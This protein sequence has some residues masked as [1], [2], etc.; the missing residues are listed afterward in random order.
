MMYFDDLEEDFEL[1][2][3]YSVQDLLPVYEEPPSYEARGQYPPA[4]IPALE[5]GMRQMVCPL[6]AFLFVP[7]NL[8][9]QDN[10][11]SFQTGA[12]V[13]VR[14]R[15]AYTRAKEWLGCRFRH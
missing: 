2:P 3:P 14:V 1:A 11:V 9:A 10:V 15:K 12:G 4:P 13:F 6:F 8:Q 7:V 5:Q